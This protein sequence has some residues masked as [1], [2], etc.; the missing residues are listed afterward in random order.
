MKMRTRR[1]VR[2]SERGVSWWRKKKGGVKVGNRQDTRSRSDAREGK[3][4]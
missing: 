1:I 3:R 2:V 4:G